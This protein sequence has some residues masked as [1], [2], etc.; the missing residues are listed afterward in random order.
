MYGAF[1]ITV[2]GLVI[3]AM[4]APETRNMSLAETSS[5]SH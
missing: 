5:L 4:W 2:V 1:A 3:S